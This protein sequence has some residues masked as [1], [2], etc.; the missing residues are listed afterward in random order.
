MF[1]RRINRCKGNSSG[2]GSSSGGRAFDGGAIIADLTLGIISP[3]IGGT[4]T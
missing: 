1:K 3:T 2:H 4:G